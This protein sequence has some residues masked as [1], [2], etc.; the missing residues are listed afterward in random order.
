M[1]L[2]SIARRTKHGLYFILRQ[3]QSF[4]VCPEHLEIMQRVVNILRPVT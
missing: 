3:K 2:F 1:S 4:E